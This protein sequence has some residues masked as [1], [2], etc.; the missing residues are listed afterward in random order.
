MSYHV[1]PC[2][3]LQSLKAPKFVYT[4]DM[5]VDKL[6]SFEPRLWDFISEMEPKVGLVEHMPQE[7]KV[8]DLF[9]LLHDSK[10]DIEGAVEGLS[11]SYFDSSSH[12]PRVTVIGSGPAGLFATL[13]LGELGADVTLIERGQPVEQR[14]RDI[15]ALV[16]RRIIQTESNFCFGEV[17]FSNSICY[18]W[19]FLLHMNPVMACYFPL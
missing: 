11:N 1:I 19:C 7:K 18:L 8:G 10:K 15:G 12:K 6:L 9:S 3:F 17:T 5:D 14:G 13:V 4:V 16:V 2:F